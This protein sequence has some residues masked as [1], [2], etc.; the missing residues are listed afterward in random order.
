MSI[1]STRQPFARICEGK[2]RLTHQKIITHQALYGLDNK[3]QH[4]PT[5]DHKTSMQK[6]QKL[7]KKVSKSFNGMIMSLT[8]LIDCCC[9]VVVSRTYE[10]MRSWVV[11]PTRAREVRAPGA[12]RSISKTSAGVARVH[13]VRYSILG[14]GMII[15]VFAPRSTTD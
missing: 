9:G 5:K 4:N 10:G 6:L 14:S 15:L 2:N 7:S 13:A 1:S 11:E 3:P 8:I 12:A